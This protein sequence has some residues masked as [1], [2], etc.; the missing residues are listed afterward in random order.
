MRVNNAV[1][2]RLLPD[3]LFQG[4]VLHSPNLVGGTLA[5]VVGAGNGASVIADGPPS[6]GLPNSNGGIY[7]F[8]SFMRPRM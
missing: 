5:N 8:P 6:S 2:L 4:M 7:D 3:E 1:A